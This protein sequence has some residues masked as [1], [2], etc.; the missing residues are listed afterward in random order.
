MAGT[1]GK[2]WPGEN[3]GLGSCMERG[4]EGITPVEYYDGL[5]FNLKPISNPLSHIPKGAW[6]QK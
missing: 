1:S 4:T 3:R 2:P 6:G 5:L